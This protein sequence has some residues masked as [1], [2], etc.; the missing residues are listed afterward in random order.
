MTTRAAARAA[1]RGRLEDA[2]GAAALWPDAILDEAIGDGVRGYGLRRPK[3]AALA[4]AA[5][6]GSTRIGLP[7]N[8]VDPARVVR[9]L[10]PRGE[11]VPPWSLHEPTGEAGQGWRVFADGLL[12]AEPARAGTWTIEHRTGRTPPA[13]DAGFLDVLPGD[14]PTVLA[15]ATAAALARR[16]TEAAKRGDRQTAD[17]CARLADAARGEADRLLGGRRRARTTTT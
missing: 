9:V 16:A 1:L 13:D 8:A 5:A 11:I 4:V 12:L 7:A 3:E 10:D 17:A 15:L 6:A 2:A 14:E